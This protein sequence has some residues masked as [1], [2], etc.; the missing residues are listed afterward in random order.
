[1]SGATE[2]AGRPI[3]VNASIAVAVTRSVG[4]MPALYVTL[5]IVSGW[6]ALATWGPLHRVDPYPFP[7]LLFLDNVVQL[8]LCPVILVGQ[9]VLGM[10]AERRAVRAAEDTE[11]IFRQLAELHT[12]LDRRDQALSR[13]AGARPVAFG[14]PGWMR[15]ARVARTEA[16]A[17]EVDVNGRVAA[18]LT[19]RLSSMWVFYAVA[20]SQVA[21]MGLAWI[22]VQRVDPYPFA[23]MTFLS[24]LA[25]LI[26]M[27]VI[28]VG[29]DVL[30]SAAALRADQMFSDAGVVSRECGRMKARLAAQ[31]RVISGLLDATAGPEHHCCYDH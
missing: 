30:G 4:S 5:V 9:R 2:E 14:S 25:Q 3:G 16:T 7:F 29:Q 17:G 27:V 6:M 31:D 8:V 18:W 1:V 19:L 24:T 12:Y 26:F 21:W 22:G 15:S 10:A 13:A 11:A 28:M 23:F 20:G